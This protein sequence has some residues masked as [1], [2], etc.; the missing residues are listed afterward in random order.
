VESGLNIRIDDFNP[1]YAKAFR[2]LNVEWISKYFEM[3]DSDYKL[4]DHPQENI[5][6]SGGFILVALAHD[7]VI[8]VCAM[9]KNENLPFD[10]ELG[11]MA[12]ALGYRGMGIGYMLL[13]SVIEKA[14]KLGS[15]TIYLESSNKLPVA[16][17]LYKKL[18]FKD[19]SG[20]PSPYVR[21]D[22]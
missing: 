3:E 19:V 7:E 21:A 12:V 11:K 5:I 6:N 8:G 10:F 9:I 4:L 18:G 13:K 22:V 1:T 16:L 20:F 17:A 14:K 15:K 2:D